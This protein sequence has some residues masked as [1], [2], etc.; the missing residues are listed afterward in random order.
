[1]AFTPSSSQGGSDLD[2]TGSS[3]GIV[4]EI[5]ITPLTDVFLVLLIIFMVTS[6][7]L[8]Q[9][10]VNVQLPQSKQASEAAE[11]GGVIV[12]VT[13]QE[14]IMVNGASVARTHI[15]DALRLALS[16]SKDKTIVL[17]GDRRAVL[18]TVVEIMDAGKKAGASKF[19][20]AT[21]PEG[22]PSKAPE[23]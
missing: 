2:G 20:V 9:M 23:R 21:A 7:V 4:A 18:G 11:P 22:G 12:T 16:R 3:D 13:G 14:Q 8:T 10:G 15:E 1:M 17:V 6:S 19:S 5:N